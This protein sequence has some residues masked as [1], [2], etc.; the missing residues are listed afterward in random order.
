MK[1][2][3]KLLYLIAASMIMACGGKKNQQ[4][5]DT[6]PPSTVTLSDQQ[7]NQLHITTAPLREY[8]FSGSIKVNGKISVSPQS[9]AIITT[10]IGANIDRILVEEGIHVSK[11]QVVA[12]LSSAEITELQSRYA[13]AINRRD[14]LSKEFERQRQMMDEKV[15][16]GKDYDR[17][18]S[19][20]QSA[21]REVSMIAAQLQQLGISASN[22]NKGAG[23]GKISLRSPIAG[24][25]ESIS[26]QTGQYATA[27]MPLMRIVNTNNTYVDLLVFQRDISKVRIGQRVRLLTGG[28][29]E[30]AGSV[31]SIANTF[32]DDVQAVHV[33][34][35]IEDKREGLIAGMYIEG[36]IDTD[37]IRRNAVTEEAIIEDDGKSYIFSASH[38]G[39]TWLFTPIE[40]KREQEE[41]GMVMVTPVDSSTDLSSIAQSGAYYILSE[42]RK[43]ETGED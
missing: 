5:E 25:V 11:G 10:K 13:N 1:M 29:K 6:T 23:V 28:D 33:R 3:N 12:Y 40:V 2:K 16:A 39:N 8:C 20:Y 37:S 31:K 26:V 34:V 38:Q 15:G 43:G 32:S 17:A 4:E 9:M 19:E 30:L 18:R 24:T 7:V 36:L 42:M 35:S 22:N 14:Y 27:D 21:C 41:N